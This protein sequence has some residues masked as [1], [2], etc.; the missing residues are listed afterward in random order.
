LLNI[1]A[2][3]TRGSLKKYAARSKL[4]G[5]LGRGLGPQA[6]SEVVH[7]TANALGM[8]EELSREDVLRVLDRLI[9]YP[10]LIG[11][12]ATFTKSQVCMWSEFSGA[13]ACSST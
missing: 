13:G 3:M 1:A 11:V 8:G 2:D 10:G 4:I 9:T 7:R 12:S 6:A 5:V